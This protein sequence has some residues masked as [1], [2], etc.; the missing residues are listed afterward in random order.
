[1]AIAAV[2]TPSTIDDL[3][4]T[5]KQESPNAGIRTTQR[6][7]TIREQAASMAKRIR[8]SRAEFMGTYAHRAH[9]LE[10]DRW[11]ANNP[12]ATAIQTTAEF[13]RIIRVARANGEIVSNHLSDSARDIS[14]PIGTPQELNLIELRIQQ[15]GGRVIREPHAAGGRHWHIDW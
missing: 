6:A 2:S 12:N 3:I 11:V 1:M 13:E 9:I 14:W 15:L 7:R 8:A 5:I 4:D 10:M